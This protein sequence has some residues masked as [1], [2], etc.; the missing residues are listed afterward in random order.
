MVGIGFLMAGLGLWSLLR[1]WQGRL[2]E[3]TWLLR[4]ALLMG[5]S[6][7][8]AV[9]CGWITTEVGRQPYTVY[10]LLRTSDS[11]SPIGTPGVATSLLAFIVVY[12]LVFGAGATFILRLMAH[13]PA[14]GETGPETDLPQ[15][16]AGIVPGPVAG[17]ARA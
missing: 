11:V 15:R 10:G 17:V 4:A 6:G 13:P 9:I 7:F 3:D 2:F 12:S 16:A 1:R 5:P 8:I 14:P